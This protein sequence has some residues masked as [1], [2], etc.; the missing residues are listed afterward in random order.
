[1]NKTRS[2]PHIF[3][4]LVLAAA[5]AAAGAQPTNLYR[6]GPTADASFLR[7]V[8]G[9]GGGV[10]ASSSAGTVTLTAQQ[11]STAFSAVQSKWP[12]KGVLA[13][14]G[15][16]VPINLQLQP[17]EFVTVVA[18]AGPDGLTSQVLRE[19][20]DDFNALKTSLAFANLAEP[21][22]AAAGLKVAGRETSLFDKVPSAMPQRRLLNPVKLS[23][24]LTCGG[25]P[26]GAPLALGQLEAGERYSVLVVPDATGARLLF[27]HDTLVP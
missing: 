16:Q 2:I 17:S 22:C 15:K 7:F 18:L 13:K 12:V 14:D 3:G 8:D 5:C 27:T 20:P 23:V 19:Q 6:A 24:Q 1:M 26:L 10:S 21:T 25:K 11:P 9:T 4:S